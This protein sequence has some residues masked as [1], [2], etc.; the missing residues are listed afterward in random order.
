V[1]LTL[2]GRLDFLEV[3]GMIET[4]SWEEDY[5][6]RLNPELATEMLR[7]GV[8]V[9]AFTNW[10]VLETG[11][12]YTRAV[13]P[14]SFEASNQHGVHQAAL[15]GLCADY[16]A[17][18]ALATIIRGVPIIGI[19]PQKDR[20]G[21]SLWSVALSVS[22]KSPSAADLVAVAEIDP[23]RQSR[24]HR[25]YFQGNTVLERVEVSL[26][27]GDREV[28]TAELTFF[29]RR[30]NM[31]RPGSTD[32]KPHPLFEH[33]LKASARLIA[34][35]R[36][37]E[38]ASS[39]PIVSDP[40]AEKAAGDHG[41]ILAERFLL[42]SPQLQPMVAARTKHIDDLIT[43][44]TG[45]RQIVLLGAGFDFR[46]FRLPMNE[47]VRVFE[48][49]FPSMLIERER[50]LSEVQ[51][52]AAFERH[53]VACDFEL[54]DLSQA[55]LDYGFDPAAKTIFVKE[56]T[57]M[58]FDDEANGK[59]LTAVASLM[60]HPESQLWVDYVKQELFQIRSRDESVNSFLDSMERMGEPFIFGVDSA[61]E[62]FGR[63]GLAV[64]ADDDARAYFPAL[65]DQPLYPL[66]RFAVARRFSREE[67]HSAP[68][69]GR[70]TPGSASDAL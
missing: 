10:K 17:G 28:A 4:I 9:L 8:P 70:E 31:I 38:S 48:V 61:Q 2:A 33:K 26:K 59:Q 47:K 18:V 46:P 14:I 20:H 25:R 53:S 7:A 55:L 58:Y 41:A 64:E 1:S 68:W 67:T 3:K 32:S 54:E 39:S 21:A 23:Q 62:W 24:I 51:L 52:R 11:P 12:G 15:I 57:S 35:L 34:A 56:G 44:S 22:Y 30:S 40:Y 50:V 66:Y 49:D 45:V 63:F 60:E 16:T 27:N 43:N 65:K 5:K 69:D 29:M 13:L 37:R 19:N 6:N 36:A 42:A